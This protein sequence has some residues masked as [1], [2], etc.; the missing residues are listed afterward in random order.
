[1]EV[2]APAAGTI[3]Q[4]KVKVG[5]EVGQDDVIASYEPADQ[6][7]GSSNDGGETSGQEDASSAAP[8][9]PARPDAPSPEDA[10]KPVKVPD[11]GDFDKVPVI[12]ILV[13]VGDRVAAEDPLLV[14]ES[15]KATMEVPAP[16][17]GTVEEILVQV[18][19][20][21]GQGDA[22]F[23][24]RS[25]SQN[26]AAEPEEKKA[27]ASNNH[28]TSTDHAAEVKTSRPAQRD[29]SQP[30]PA[31]TRAVSAAELPHA[32]PS[33]RKFAREL[34][35][36]LQQVQGSGRKGRILREDVQGFV[37]HNLS[38]GSGHA[39]LPQAPQVDY[40]KFGSVEEVPL[41]RIRQISASHLQ[42][43]WQ[44]VPHVTQNDW[45]D[46]TD[47]ED[48][49]RQHNAQ[50]PQTKLTLLA[51]VLK[52]CAV[53]LQRYP[54]FNSALGAD[55]KHLI[56]RHYLNLGFAAD[57]ENGLVVPVIRD[58]NK[59]TLTELAA[60]AAELAAAAR[61]GKL[62]PAQMQGGCFSVSSLGGIGG[63]H[64]TPI[65]NSPEVAILGVSKALMQPQWDGQS[66]VPRLM[67]PLSL[68][69]DHRV[70]DGA[71]AAR[72]TTDLGALLTDIRR[73]LL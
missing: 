14:L 34:G 60:E 36:D 3:T 16:E 65:V 7:S 66:F 53:L 6:E 27:A 5:D 67:C 46:I 37:Q 30:P 19:D 8:A 2:P 52:A 49:R 55:G 18:G 13:A 21:V 28:D 10:I 32:S 20:S 9:E 33:I 40:A 57:T 25:S 42:R 38:T 70:I 41:A 15:D 22:I 71:A 26:S 43:S 12:E 39:G 59:K 54:D 1:M 29:A 69:Y 31:G 48:F 50:G 58:V 24:L 63:A 62:K 61:S 73:L 4:L 17:G 68:S 47:L 44:H 11:I 56:R 35:V 45:A 72:F 64:F 23:H 51:F